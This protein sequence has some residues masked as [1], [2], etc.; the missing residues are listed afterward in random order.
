FSHIDEPQ[1]SQWSRIEHDLFGQDLFSALGT[2]AEVEPAKL[3]YYDYPE[4]EELYKIGV[5][6]VYLSNYLRW[7][8]LV[9]NSSALS[10]G[11]VPQKQNATFDPYERAGSSIYYKLHDLLRFKR[12]GY[13][14]CRDQLV[15]EIRHGRIT[16]QQGA[17]LEAEYSQA[18]VDIR[19]FFNWLD[20][21]D[22]GFQWF[23]K[24]R[25]IGFESLI[26]SPEE[27]RVSLPSSV[28]Q[29][30]SSSASPEYDFL[31]FQKGISLG[32]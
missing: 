6:G 14:K 8:P 5:A 13:R 27:S 20:V 25:L 4:I 28:K 16:R 30:I 26:G 9:Q 19:A 3:H 10:A 29:Y 12:I 24:H 11:F 22:S 18:S 15:R 1:M 7:D 23:V 21:T 31:R 32:D 17:A 2:G